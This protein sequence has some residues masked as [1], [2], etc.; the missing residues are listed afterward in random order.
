MA[1]ASAQDRSVLHPYASPA[2]HVCMPRAASLR[3]TSRS[4]SPAIPNPSGACLLGRL[5]TFPPL[6]LRSTDSLIRCSQ[7]V[8]PYPTVAVIMTQSQ[9]KPSKKPQGHSL[10]YGLFVL[11]FLW[12]QYH[13][14][15]TIRFCQHP[16]PITGTGSIRR[17]NAKPLL[18]CSLILLLV[19][20]CHIP[21]I[22]V[23]MP[24]QKLCR[25]LLCLL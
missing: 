11:V 7:R 25:E 8:F 12:Q 10:R 16:N 23:D 13:R 1:Y 24:I 21:P 2:A 22:T 19:C 14:C 4:V 6:A 20:V 18:D 5:R 17:Q 3:D 9:K 15:R